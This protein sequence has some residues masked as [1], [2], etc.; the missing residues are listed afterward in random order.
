ME[1]VLTVN[2]VAGGTAQNLASRG[3]MCAEN[4]HTFLVFMRKAHSVLR[5]I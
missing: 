4:S 5:I 2:R 3:R 1:T